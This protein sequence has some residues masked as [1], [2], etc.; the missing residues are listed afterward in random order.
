MFQLV[1]LSFAADDFEAEGERGID[2]IL[3]TA[4]TFNK[5]HNITGMLLYKGGVFL[6]ILEGKREDVQ[7][8][9][10]KICMDLRHFG[11]KILVKQDVVGRIFDEWTMAY[12]K[13]DEINADIVNMILP[14][15]EI[16]DQTRA[17]HHITKDKIL[18]IFKKFRFELGKS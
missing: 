3:H 1:Y 16:V 12:K 7:M 8:L 6:Q 10:G 14:W 13:V 17:N 18:E 15:Q 11:Q 5:E 2:D 9:Y 4:R